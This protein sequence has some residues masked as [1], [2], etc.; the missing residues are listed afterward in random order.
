MLDIHYLSCKYVNLL[1][2]AM[3]P[4]PLSAV[5]LLNELHINK[6]LFCVGFRPQQL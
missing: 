2:L 4:I 3:Q 5:V 6:L 1:V